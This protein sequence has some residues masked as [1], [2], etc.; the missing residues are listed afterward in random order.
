MS[1]WDLKSKYP[2]QVRYGSTQDSRLL[3]QM[4]ILYLQTHCLAGNPERNNSTITDG[5]KVLRATKS[6]YIEETWITL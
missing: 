2:R 5:I 3:L 4:S 1:S 6:Y